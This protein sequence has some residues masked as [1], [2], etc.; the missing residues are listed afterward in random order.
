[1]NVRRTLHLLL[2]L[3]QDRNLRPPQFAQQEA[4]LQ[5]NILTGSEFLFVLP[6]LRMTFVVWRGEYNSEFDF[7]A[8]VLL[9]LLDYGL[10]FRGQLIQNSGAH[11]SIVSASLPVESSPD[12]YDRIR[13]KHACFQ[14]QEPEIRGEEF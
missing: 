11:S 12:C 1:M 8:R 3:N 4:E 6:T 10:P 2:I 7:L 5:H 13:R 14:A 9:K